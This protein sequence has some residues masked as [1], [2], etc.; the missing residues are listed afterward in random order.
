MARCVGLAERGESELLPC[1]GV[2]AREE[3]ERQYLRQEH[4][5]PVRAF[6]VFAFSQLHL[7]AD[8]LPQ[9]HLASAAQ[10]Q[11]WPERLQQV[12]GTVMVMF[13]RTGGR[14]VVGVFVFSM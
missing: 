9:E 8:C 11:D 1:N 13:I 3:R 4:R 10:A 14:F 6:S 7:R 5:A 12:V 2:L